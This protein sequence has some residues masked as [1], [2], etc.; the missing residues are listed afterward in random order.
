MRAH[1]ENKDE[2]AIAADVHAAASA[3]EEILR[4]IGAS[5]HDAIVTID[6]KGCV[7]FWNGAA[8]KMFGFPANE[9]LG[10]GICTAG[11]AA[12][13]PHGPA[14]GFCAFSCHGRRNRDGQDLG[15]RGPAERR[16]GV[17]R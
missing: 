5:A 1:D 8:E 3:E 9:I 14:G 17:S 2:A 13:I 11:C 10:L 16:K 15:T 7:A 6:H 12:T 4:V